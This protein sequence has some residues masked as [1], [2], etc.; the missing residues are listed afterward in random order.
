MYEQMQKEGGIMF[1]IHCRCQ[2]LPKAQK[3]ISLW[4]SYVT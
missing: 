4:I 2:R 3:W 1:L